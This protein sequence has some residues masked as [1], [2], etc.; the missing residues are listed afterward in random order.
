M[1]ETLHHL[2][3]KSHLN[4]DFKETEEQLNKKDISPPPS[5]NKTQTIKTAQPLTLLGHLFSLLSVQ[6]QQVA[7]SQA[8]SEFLALTAMLAILISVLYNFLGNTNP[9]IDDEDSFEEFLLEMRLQTMER[10]IRQGI[11]MRLERALYS[12]AIMGV[13]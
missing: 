1:E 4:T 13:H 7:A 10:I 2:T 3:K 8:V 9:P 11:E 5:N 6:N 12:R